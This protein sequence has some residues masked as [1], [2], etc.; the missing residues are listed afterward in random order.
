MAVT[1]TAAPA[2]GSSFAGW[3]GDC[4]GAATTCQLTMD[5]AKNATA[6]FATSSDL[7][8]SPLA[9]T[10]GSGTVTTTTWAPARSR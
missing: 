1:L 3:S 10:G 7:F 9:L 8:A 5:A 6:T 2:T 4:T